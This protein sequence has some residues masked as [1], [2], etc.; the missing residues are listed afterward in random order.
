MAKIFLIVLFLGI[1][2]GCQSSPA[3]APQKYSSE[4]IKSAKYTW[5]LLQQAS[6]GQAVRDG[7]LSVAFADLESQAHTNDEVAAKITLHTNSL[8]LKRLKY[9]HSKKDREEIAAKM[10]MN[11]CELD[12]MLNK[13][14]GA[15][16]AS[17]GCGENLP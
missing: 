15:Y 6:E 17:K 14:T 1:L 2:S 4:F 12:A 9:E 10:K 11:H 13:G 8:L 16:E 7:D 3:A 5:S